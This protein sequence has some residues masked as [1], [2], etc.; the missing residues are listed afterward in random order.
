MRNLVCILIFAAAAQHCIAQTTD[1]ITLHGNYQGIGLFVQNPC[2][3]YTDQ[4]IIVNGEQLNTDIASAYEIIL[5][6][7]TS[8]REI[9]D[10]IDILII[11]SLDCLPRVLN[12]EVLTPRSS[13]DIISMSVDSL[14]A[15]KWTARHET[16]KLNYDIEQ[17]IWKKWRIVSVQPEKSAGENSYTVKVRLH[18][19]KN[20]FR[21]KQVDYSRR[22][23]YS[24]KVETIS[25]ALKVTVQDTIIKNN[26]VI[27]SDTTFYQIIDP[28]DNILGIGTGIEVDL[29]NY[30]KGV[31]LKLNYDGRSTMIQK[32]KRIRKKYKT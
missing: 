9:G 6:D 8:V 32:G 5:A 13:F 14:G 20:L 31:P 4:I 12:P 18:Y 19:G 15:L 21:I 1:T 27:F 2:G 28:F 10:K 3:L 22:P 11:H 7:A 23:R 24:S 25:K 17:F 30:S 26:K 16:G 29:K